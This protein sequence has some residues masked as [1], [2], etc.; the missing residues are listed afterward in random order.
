LSPT[1]KTIT[2]LSD[3]GLDDEYAGV[4]HAVIAR[5][6][7]QAR[8][9]D[10]SHGIPPGDV[11]VGALV[12]RGAL[13]YA[14][15]GVHLAVVDPGV[16]GARRAVA[17]RAGEQLLVGPDNGLLIPAAQ[18]LGGVREAVALDQSPE[19]LEPVSSTFHGRDIFAPVAAALAAGVELGDV[20][21][22]LDPSSLVELGMPVARVEPEG[23]VAQ[24]VHCDHFGNV[25]LGADPLQLQEIGIRPGTR[26]TVRAP[27]ARGPAG[28]SA[29]AAEHAATYATTFADVAEGHL[30]LYTDSLGMVAL[31]VNR[32]SAGALLGVGRGQQLTLAPARGR[33]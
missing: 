25:I 3:Y 10:L 19:R 14:P 17:L 15:A 23:L 33:A 27:G 30:L 24:V 4:C 32:G 26:I 2:F 31:A 29:S 21:A 7:P 5:R 12:L 22:P 16:G 28:R 1:A 9:I 13:P 20:G 11:R 6:C 8:V 18:C